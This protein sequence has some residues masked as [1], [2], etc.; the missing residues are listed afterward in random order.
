MVFYVLKRIGY[1][2]YSNFTRMKKHLALLLLVLSATHFSF[3][4]PSNEINWLDFN[5]G[6]KLAK[7]KKK[8]LLVDV[9][10]DWCGWCKVMDRETYAKPEIISIVEKSYIAVKFNPELKDVV[11]TYNGKTYNGRELAQVISNNQLSGYP[12]TLFMDVNSG[13]VSVLSGYQNPVEF[14]ATLQ[15]NLEKH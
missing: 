7:K 14:K 2:R 6:Y 11:Y 9:Y 3:T 10:T 4:P 1:F 12:T 15:H 13:R 5:T 8:M